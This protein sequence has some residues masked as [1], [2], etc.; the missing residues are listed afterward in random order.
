M[1]HLNK[2]NVKVAATAAKGHVIEQTA[3]VTK[4]TAPDARDRDPH[5]AALKWIR[6]S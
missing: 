1:T 4:R 6:V 3:P 5:S 2:R